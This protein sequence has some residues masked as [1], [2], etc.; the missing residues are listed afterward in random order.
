MKTGK[1]KYHT[2]LNRWCIVTENNEIHYLDPFCLEIGI[3]IFGF[4]HACEILYNDKESNYYVK[5]LNISFNL[6]K[7]CI[8]DVEFQIWEEN[9]IPF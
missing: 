7:S 8:Y 3:K 9:M 6:K 2:V 4:Y 1:L 5:F